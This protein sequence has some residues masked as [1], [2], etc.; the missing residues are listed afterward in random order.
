M[1]T[2]SLAVLVGLTLFRGHTRALTEHAASKKRIIQSQR[3]LFIFTDT[4]YQDKIKSGLTDRRS[5]LP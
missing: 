4:N 5:N 3:S 1:R 2:A